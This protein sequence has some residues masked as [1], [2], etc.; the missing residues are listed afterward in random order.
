MGCQ[1]P[2]LQ[3]QLLPGR[4][5][6]RWHYRFQVTR[7]WDIANPSGIDHAATRTALKKERAAR[8]EFQRKERV[9]NK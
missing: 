8:K 5:I 6:K 2:E 4:R 3:K 7:S 1:D 9:K